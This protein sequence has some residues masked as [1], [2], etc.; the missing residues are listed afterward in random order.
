MTAPKNE[1][2]QRTTPGVEAQQVPA[3]ADH[4]PNGVTPEAEVMQGDKA[5]SE[6]F[7]QPGGDDVI[8]LD[9]D[10]RIAVE[11]AKTRAEEKAEE[12]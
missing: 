1:N 4:E 9:T 11:P 5:R 7:D 12:R 10:T 8:V 2:R 3:S 6:V